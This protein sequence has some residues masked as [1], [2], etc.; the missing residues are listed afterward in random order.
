[1]SM[2]IIEK[3]DNCIDKDQA[4]TDLIESVALMENGL[5]HIINAEGEKIQKVIKHDRDE[6]VS[7]LDIYKVNESARRMINT[8]SRLEV[9]L[10]GKLDIV[11]DLD[12]HYFYEQ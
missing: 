8:I 9:L 1:M 4:I 11:K 3:H 12:Y 2:P 7:S 5:A 10:Q 6:E